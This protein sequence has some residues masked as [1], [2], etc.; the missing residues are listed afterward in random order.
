[1]SSKPVCVKCNKKIL[2]KQFL[3]CATCK[4]SFDL[5]CTSYEKL[6]NLMDNDRKAAWTCNKC[7]ETILSEET[8]TST[9]ILSKLNIAVPSTSKKATKVPAKKLKNKVCVAPASEHLMPKSTFIMQT[10]EQ[11][12]ITMKRPTYRKPH[13]LSE[14]SS[15]Q[16][17]EFEL[18][19]DTEL[20]V[21]SHSL[22]NDSTIEDP[23][24]YELKTQVS[25]L[26]LHL[27]SAHEEID[28]LNTEVA[29]LNKKL[30]DQQKKAEIFKKLL[31]DKGPL[32]K[33]TPVKKGILVTNRNHNMEILDSDDDTPQYLSP[34]SIPQDSKKKPLDLQTIAIREEME[35]RKSLAGNDL[36][37]EEQSKLQKTDNQTLKSKNKIL[38][39]STNNK[40]KTLHIIRNN[41]YFDNFSF[42]H[43]VK[44]GVGI[45]CLLNGLRN[46]LKD[47][48]R[49]DYC[50][51]LVGEEDFRDLND[52]ISLVMDIKEVVKDITFTNI[53]IA[54]PTYIC[55]R[56]LYNARVER[57][58]SLLFED[59]TNHNECFFVYDSNRNLS[60]DMFSL[61][62]GRINNYG[63]MNIITNLQYNINWHANQK[64]GYC[65]GDES[66][67]CTRKNSNNIS[68]N[69]DGFFRI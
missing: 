13:F 57:F 58:N 40:N 1:M 68:C 63:M 37:N 22:P 15:D 20:N 10:S 51:I 39:L 65:F 52:Y 23:R 16:D 11:E 49:C 29:G 25:T 18:L 64:S 43:Y 66:P 24:I 8:K 26:S 6:F 41:D 4:G 12:N 21:S 62:T 44:P 42:C 30:V 38:L 3:V 54:C 35:S 14:V 69:K 9:P 33:L 28:R 50:V 61:K 59:L 55:G 31:T 48:T 19:G 36:N 32:K 60:F 17:S 2:G 56:P 5:K 47:F 34:A 45:A 27:E 7:R 67:P 46:Q 53:I